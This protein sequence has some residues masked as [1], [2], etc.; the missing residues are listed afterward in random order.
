MNQK[1][2]NKVNMKEWD[3]G[4]G[5]GEYEQI[6]KLKLTAKH[7]LAVGRWQYGKQHGVDLR[8]YSYNENRLLAQ[9]IPLTTDNMQKLYNI[10]H[11]LYKDEYFTNFG[12]RDNSEYE[13]EIEISDGFTLST[14]IFESTYGAFQ[15]YFCIN[16]MDKTGQQVKKSWITQ[17]RIMIRFDTMPEF[18]TKCQSYKLVTPSMP[19]DE[20][21]RP[22]DPE[23]GRDIY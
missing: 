14:V 19:P 18:L 10:I 12:D 11:N 21:E 8:R 22:T 23:T 3:D 7:A 13:K 20:G 17:I 5:D 4:D 15:K 6:F 16:M 1:E 9:G 2:L